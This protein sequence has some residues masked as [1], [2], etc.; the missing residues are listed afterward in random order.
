MQLF[1]CSDSLLRAAVNF[2]FAMET[3][4]HNTVEPRFTNLIHSWRPFITRNVCKPELSVLSGSYTHLTL[5][6]RYS[7]LVAGSRV[8]YETPFVT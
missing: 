7:Q 8:R 2:I 5:S 1:E 3:D 4:L 6:R